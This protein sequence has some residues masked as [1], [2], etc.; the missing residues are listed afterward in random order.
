MSSSNEKTNQ[1]AN[2][3]DESEMKPEEG[4]FQIQKSKTSRNKIEKEKPFKTD[5]SRYSNG[6]FGNNDNSNSNSNNNNSNSNGNNNGNNNRNKQRNQSNANQYTPPQVKEAKSDKVDKV[7]KVENAAEFVVLENNRDKFENIPESIDDFEDMKFLSED[8]L[9]GIY[10]YGF[11]YPSPIQSKTIH[12][13]NGGHDLIAQSQSGT[14]KTG[15]FTIGSLS[16][17]D[18]TIKQPQ[19]IILANTRTLACQIM[20][21]VEN[22]SSEMNISACL[23]VGGSKTNSYDNVGQARTSQVLVGTPGRI[24]EL[25]SKKTFNGKNIKTLVLDEADELLKADFREQIINI[26]QYMGKNTQICIFSA[27]FTKETLKLTEN[28]LT[29]P[30]RI[31]I[32][33]EELSL[34]RVKQFWIDIQYEKAK[35]ACLLDLFKKLSITQMIIFVNSVGSAIDLRN[36]MMDNEIEVGL[37]HGKLTNGDKETV[38]KEFR[39][40]NIRI[41]ISTDIM[42]R[43]I[44]IDDLRIVINYDMSHDSET[45]IHRIGRSGRYG[46]QGVALNF[47]T[48]DDRHKIGILERDYKMNIPKMPRP[49]RINEY[50]VG[51]T[52]PDDKVLSSKNYK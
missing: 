40:A 15:A 50:L 30:Y 33:N 36:K 5:N 51:M 24:A 32:E 27:T 41:L 48:Y 35:F 11:K 8:L 26:V 47:C 37:I 43:G 52:L 7:D 9:L 16:G 21:V 22:L 18:P 17:C 25:I 19:V 28:F 38:L 23:C 12:I 1:K 13:I 29:N 46:G 6:R 34:D 31:T 3:V 2:A 42:C 39:L 10:K 44:D 20:K 45:Y 49:E 4:E 14:G